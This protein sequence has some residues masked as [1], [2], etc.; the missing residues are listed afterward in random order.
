MTIH[1]EATSANECSEPAFD[2]KVDLEGQAAVVLG[3]SGSIGEQIALRLLENGACVTVVSRSCAS[4][5]KRLADALD[6]ETALDFVETDASDAQHMLALSRRI[7]RE[8]GAL[9]ILVLAHGVQHRSAVVDCSLDQWNHVIRNNLTS[10]FLSCKFL[11]RSMLERGAG[12]LIALTSLT[13]EIGIPDIGPYAASK[14]GISQ[15]MQTVAVEWAHRNVTVNSIAPGRIRTRMTEDL[16]R[17]EAVRE[18]NLRCIPQGRL[19]EPDD[20]SGAALFLCSKAARY[21]TGQTL[22]VDGGWLASGG[23]PAA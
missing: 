3:G 21:I 7:E 13:S 22:V 14:G 19:G 2:L 16:L 17:D 9:D 18:A 15:L 11:C 23:N 5:S 1:H 8:S 12:R 6:T 10:A 4:I 20:I